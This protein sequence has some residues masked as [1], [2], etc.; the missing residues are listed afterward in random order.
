MKRHFPT[1]REE[2]TNYNIQK[3]Y[4]SIVNTVK[5]GTV[6]GQEIS[7]EDFR[8]IVIGA[9][10]LGRSDSEYIKECIRD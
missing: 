7:E 3:E 4:E 6:Y 1:A 10:W 8:T 2:W 5:G 9:Y